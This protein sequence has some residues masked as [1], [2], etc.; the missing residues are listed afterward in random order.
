MTP[1]ETAQLIA[2]AI[3]AKKGL[4]IR[5]LKIRDL[6]VLADYFVIATGTSSTQVKALAGEVEAKTQAAGFAPLRV[7][8]FDGGGWILLDYNSVIVH[9]FQPATRNFYSLERLW[10]DAQPVDTSFLEH[11]GED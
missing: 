2:G 1:L 11:P 3:N 7:E 4:D 8:G 9:I 10:A 6:T 5:I